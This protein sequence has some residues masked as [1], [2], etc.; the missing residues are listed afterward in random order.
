MFPKS[1]KNQKNIL[2][3]LLPGIFF[4]ILCC[5]SGKKSF[6]QKKFFVFTRR[7]TEYNQK[8]VEKG[9]V[10]N[11]AKEHLTLLQQ[12]YDK[13][14]FAINTE[15][16]DWIRNPFSVNAEMSMKELPLHIQE[17]FFEVRHNRTLKLKFSEV[18]LDMFWIST[19]KNISKFPKWLLEFCFNFAQ[20]ICVMKTFHLYYKSK[21][22]NDPA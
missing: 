19:K 9:F 10:L 12:K 11:S 8:N 21:T 7:T 4:I 15:K 17:N 22:I 5:S 6:Q 20:L 3:F 14:F 13:Y 2:F 16:Y 18:Q 1:Y